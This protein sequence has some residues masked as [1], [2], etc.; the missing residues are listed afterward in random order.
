MPSPRSKYFSDHATPDQLQAQYWEGK[1]TRAEAQKIFD[2]FGEALN[3]TQGQLTALNLTV[4]YLIK[5]FDISPDE[6]KAFVAEK[7]NE[8]PHTGEAPSDEPKVTLT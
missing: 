7:L 4:A 8:V 5:K 6:F 3:A 2:E 1:I